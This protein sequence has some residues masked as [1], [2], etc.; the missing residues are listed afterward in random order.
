MSFKLLSTS[1]SLNDMNKHAGSDIGYCPYMQINSTTDTYKTFTESMLAQ[2]KT[3]TE[4]NSTI[5]PS[6]P[7]GG[8]YNASQVTAPWGSIPVVPTDSNIIHLNLRS[9]NPPPGATE[10]YVSTNRLGNN[11]T[12]KTGVYA[13]NPPGAT[14]GMYRMDVTRKSDEVQY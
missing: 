5:P 13:Y 3:T 8:L 6:L 12:S 14:N 7:N 11:Y 2:D 10:Q 4:E 1:M 9:A